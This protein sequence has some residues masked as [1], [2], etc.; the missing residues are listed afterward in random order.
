MFKRLRNNINWWKNGLRDKGFRAR[1]LVVIL[2]FGIAGILWGLECF[3]GIVARDEVFTNP[4]SFI[5][6]AVF[7]GAIGGLSLALTKTRDIKQVIK[8]LILGAIGCFFGFL[9]PY[10]FSLILIIAGGVLNYFLF[11]SAYFIE[12]ISLGAG[13]LFLTNFTQLGNLNPSLIFSG[14][15]LE[16]FFTGAIIG[17]VYGLIFKTK[18]LSVVLKTAIY[19]A[20]ASLIAPILGNLIGVAFFNSLFFA[21]IITFIILGTGLGIPLFES[22]EKQNN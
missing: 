11:L 6:G 5:L 20:V 9:L 2:G 17:L 7:F 22:L 21:Y 3:N 19:F 13:D 12:T 4:F 1:F 8:I 15:W 10:L 18:I 16:F 14:L